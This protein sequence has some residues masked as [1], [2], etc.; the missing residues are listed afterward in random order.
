MS[1][2]PLGSCII[3]VLILFAG[4]C[5]NQTSLPITIAV[6]PSLSALGSGQKIQL[7]ATITNTTTGVTSPATS[8]DTATGITWA[9][10]VGTIDANGN[11][12]APSGA[13]SSTGYVIA[14]SKEDR[15]K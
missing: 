5:T 14:T 3:F 6:T 4:G 2:K 10:T 15:T 11:Y 9:A 7:S 13:Q 1:L 12:T 8:N